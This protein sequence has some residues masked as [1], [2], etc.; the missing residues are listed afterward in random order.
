MDDLTPSKRRSP[1]LKTIAGLTGL[2][3]PTVSRALSGALDISEDT[4]ARVRAVADEIGYV[5]NRAG[6]RL[7][8]GRTN[9][10]SL[11]MSTEHDVMNHTAKLISSVAAGLRNTPF[12]LII[13]PY[14]ADEDPMKPIR[15]IV[16]TGSADAVIFNQIKPEDPR[17]QYLLDRKF[18]FA[19]HG[20]SARCDEH[21][22]FDFDNA[23]F[24]QLGVRTLA[25]RGRRKLALVAPPIDQ[26]YAQAMVAGCKAEAAAQGVDLMVVTGFNSDS[27]VTDVQAK[28]GALL[29]GKDVPD[30]VITG[31][32]NSALA[33]GAALLA[34]GL[35]MGHDVDIYTKEALNFMR[36]VWPEV[37]AISEDVS[38]AGDFLARAAMAQVMDPDARLMQYL[39]KPTM[40]D[41][42]RD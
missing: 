12:H 26:S 14:F 15:Y 19:T 27:P 23:A 34:N 8:T 29:Q 35:T 33:V 22:W 41:I 3:V 36:R 13:T 20:R 39:D 10:V 9:V 21:A 28:F 38:A 16:E 6:V 40:A 30:G 11:V 24:G 25:R 1:T 32:T 4:R 5:P 18:P 31:S 17:V 42:C 2:A 7:R 37:L